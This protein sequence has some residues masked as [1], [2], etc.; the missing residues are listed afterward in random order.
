MDERI[1]WM[2]QVFILENYLISLHCV[3]RIDSSWSEKYLFSSLLPYLWL[4]SS[5][6]SRTEIHLKSYIATNFGDGGYF[7]LTADRTKNAGMT[8]SHSAIFWVELEQ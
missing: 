8:G 6:K 4:L 7:H 1:S 5:D 2:V 3:L